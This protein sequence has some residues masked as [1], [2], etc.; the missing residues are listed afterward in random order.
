MSPADGNDLGEDRLRKLLVG[1][2]RGKFP[3][4]MHLNCPFT[5][6]MEYERKSKT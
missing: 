4:K 1:N 5:L 3:E 2:E 6:T